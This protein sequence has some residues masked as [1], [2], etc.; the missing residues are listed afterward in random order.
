[1]AEEFDI[2]RHEQ[3]VAYLRATGRIADEAPITCHTLAGGVSNRAV[4]VDLDNGRAWVLKQ[5]LAKLRVKD[6]WLS[7]P[8]RIGREAQ[9]LR[10]LARL[11]PPG[12]I[13][14]LVFEDPAV[15]LLAMEAVP[16]PHENLKAILLAGA[17]P[18]DRLLRLAARFGALL[19]AIHAN[20]WRRADEVCPAFEDRSFFLSLR[21]DPY[22]RAT[23]ARE[24][25]AAGFYADLIAHTGATRLTLTHGDYSPKNVLVRPGG[26]DNGVG[27]RAGGEERLVLLDHEVIH[28][29]DPAFDVGFALAHLLSKAHHLASRRA[30]F[31]GAAVHFWESYR[32]KLAGTGA[33]GAIPWAADIE[34]WCVSHAL[35]CLLARVSGKSPLEYLDDAERGRQRAAVLDLL[36]RPP[37]TTAELAGAFV[38]ALQRMK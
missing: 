29:G 3:L 1:M 11:A 7:D 30:D 33:S 25:A 27:G 12:A 22:Y 10:Y 34:S 31:Q 2:E 13:T 4:W 35:G 17:L 5:A 24:P 6:E 15:H 36:R 23:A 28:W 21:I 9:G 38:A 26:D 16:H 18:R 37:G 8:A 20:A 19:G 32:D 14:P